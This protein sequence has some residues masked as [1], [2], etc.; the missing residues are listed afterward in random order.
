MLEGI[1]EAEARIFLEQSL[2]AGGLPQVLAHTTRK[3]LADN[4]QETMFFQGNSMMRAFEEYHFRWQQRSAR[5]YE[6]AAQVSKAL[7]R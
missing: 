1:Q 2:Q 4:L 6:A 5:L 7:K 3:L